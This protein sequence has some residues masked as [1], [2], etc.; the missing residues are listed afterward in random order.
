[1]S[2]KAWGALMILIP[3]LFFLVWM[4]VRAWETA[5]YWWMISSR[6]DK[7]KTARWIAIWL[8]FAVASLL[9]SID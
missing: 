1:M 3:M 4:F 2:A 6:S 7:L 5:E 8:Y 9:L